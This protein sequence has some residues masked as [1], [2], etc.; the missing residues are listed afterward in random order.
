MI[1]LQVESKLQQP[2]R[3]VRF[4]A[5]SELRLI[6]SSRSYRSE[7]SYTNDQ[8]RQFKASAARDAL[9]IRSLISQQLKEQQSI[10]NR[11]LLKHDNLIG[12][13]HL[14]SEE[15][16]LERDYDRHVHIAA[17]LN[18]QRL[19]QEKYHG[20]D[21]SAKLAKFASLSSFKS[22]DAAIL[23]ASFSDVS[24]LERKSARSGRSYTRGLIVG[25]KANI[26]VA[27][28]A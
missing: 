22:A 12:I 2:E 20:K 5:Y 15:V 13:E 17:V 23:R 19:L 14:I 7:K 28:T 10:V 6:S 11:G 27:R 8:L 16:A 9:G 25:N 4:A 21:V 1:R 3:R 26:K 24:T 18:A